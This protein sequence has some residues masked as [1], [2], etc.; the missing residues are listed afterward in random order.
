MHCTQLRSCCS[1]DF[2]D[3][4]VDFFELEPPR[5]A[6]PD[7]DAP[8]DPPQEARRS[9]VDAAS[10]ATSANRCRPTGRPFLCAATVLA[11]ARFRGPDKV[12][13]AGE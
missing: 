6:T 9:A 3:F 10:T 8:E 5:L 13:S 2:D 7:D 1:L 11:T 4:D 12:V